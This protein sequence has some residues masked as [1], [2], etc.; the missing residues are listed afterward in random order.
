MTV[1]YDIQTN[2]KSPQNPG[3][4]SCTAQEQT[5][6]TRKLQGDT[7]THTQKE[8][9]FQQSGSSGVSLTSSYFLH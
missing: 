9:I 8:S 6:R 2:K 4:T 5:K 7:H 1:Y 3:W